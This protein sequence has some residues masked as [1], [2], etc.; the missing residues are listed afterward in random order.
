MHEP[1]ANHF[2][3]ALEAFA[4][5][6]AGAAGHGAVVRAGLG[7]DVCV[8]TLYLDQRCSL[9][10]ESTSRGGAGGDRERTYLSRYC[11]WNGGATHPG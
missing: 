5:V 2:I 11:V 8:R 1:M 3:F 4:A 7:V 6:G 9:W 10:V